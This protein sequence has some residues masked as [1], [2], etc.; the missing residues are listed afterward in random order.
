MTNMTLKALIIEYTLCTLY[1]DWDGQGRAAVWV[2]TFL[3]EGDG[4][5]CCVEFI[6]IKLCLII[7]KN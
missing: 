1:E 6:S 2:G 3:G 4:V 5:F 7:K